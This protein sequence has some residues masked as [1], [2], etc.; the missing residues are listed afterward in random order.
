M[1][2]KILYI[3]VFILAI[4][5]IAG[6]VVFIFRGKIVEHYLPVVEQIGDIHI[7]IKNDTSYINSKLTVKNK[8]FLKIKI[9][10]IKYKISL[11]EKTYLQSQKFIGILLSSYGMDTIDFPLKIPYATILKDLRTERKKGD[12]ASYTINIALQY[13]TVFGKAEI[14]INRSAKLKIPQPPELE[15]VEINSK[16]FRL[17]SIHAVARIKVI[18]YSAVTLEIKG[19]RYSMKI[20]DQGNLTGNYNQT[21]NIKPNGATFVN[22]PLE[23]NVDNIGRTIFDILM[24]KDNYDYTLTLNAFLESTDPIKESFHIDLTKT[25]KMELK[26]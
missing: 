25:G 16:K 10:T 14:P 20:L 19:M 24:N 15:I 17:K 6:G 4:A 21:I 5:V 7:K 2:N 23:I 26:K 22:L 12:S 3:C 18:N 13:S 11:F 1:K 8:S 9:D